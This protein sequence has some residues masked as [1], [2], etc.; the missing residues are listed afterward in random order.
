MKIR[1]ENESGGP[2]YGS[3]IFTGRFK[4]PDDFKGT[5]VPVSCLFS[6]LILNLSQ[7]GSKYQPTFVLLTAK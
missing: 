1:K 6:S 4:L 2:Q 5:R 7:E 3:H